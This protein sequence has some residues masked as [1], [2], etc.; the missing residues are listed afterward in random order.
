MSDIIYHTQTQ[1]KKIFFSEMSINQ[2]QL[3]LPTVWAHLKTYCD[4]FPEITDNYHWEDP[5]FVK[6]LSEKE[7]TD[8]MFFKNYINISFDVM[9]FSVYTWNWKAHLAVAKLLKKKNPHSLCIFGGPQISWQDEEI[10]K[11][12]PFIDIIVRGEGEESISEILI[13]RLR[14]QNYESIPGL[15]INRNGNRVDTGDH[16]IF[17]KTTNTPSPWL[18]QEDRIN[19]LLSSERQFRGMT[20]DIGKSWMVYETNKG[21]PY[22]CT[23]CD[24]GQV[25]DQ[26]IRKV[27]MQRIYDEIQWM[28]RT[29]I[30]GVYLGDANFGVFDRDVEIA[31]WI[32]ESHD[33]TG[34]PNSMYINY[35][36]N[37]NPRRAEIARIMEPVLPFAH[38]LDLQSTDEY[39]LESIRRRQGSFSQYKTLAKQI[40]EKGKHSILGSL[41][42]GC[43]GETNKSWL[44][45]VTDLFE[46]SAHA[47][48]L[49][50]PWLQFPNSPASDPEYIK[51][52]QIETIHR[53][54]RVTHMQVREANDWQQSIDVLVSNKDMSRDDWVKRLVFFAFCIGI[55]SHNIFKPIAFLLRHTYNVS[56]YDI[57]TKMFEMFLKSEHTNEIVQEVEKHYYDYLNIEKSHFMLKYKEHRQFLLPDIWMFMKFQDIDFE[58]FLQ[59]TYEKHWNKTV[60]LEIWQDVCLFRP[61]FYIGVN[62]RRNITASLKYDWVRYYDHLHKHYYDIESVDINDFY[63]DHILSWDFGENCDRFVFNPKAAYDFF[64]S[65]THNAYKPY[66]IYLLTVAN[67]SDTNSERTILNKECFSIVDN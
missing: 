2:S 60:P 34:F 58:Q 67:N 25:T 39:T 22:K 30:Y 16:R 26:K 65:Q 29:N 64:E 27:D 43:P 37:T 3:Y 59:E 4:L 20:K 19:S 45:T 48:A 5:L 13:Q 63:R 6:M 49:I 12:Y 21:C 8:W 28:S 56:Y 54:T 66:D 53:P 46:L 51:E 40:R 23:F 61:M 24:W 41:I 50:H 1:K 15:F 57:Y 62:S 35:A 11:K 17:W 55:H 32:R 18:M 38:N 44:K 47:G 10:F 52:W 33:N 9:C 31:Q 14:N 42:V 7:V 36:K